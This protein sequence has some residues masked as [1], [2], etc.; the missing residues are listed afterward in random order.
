M[1][2]Q[3]GFPHHSPLPVGEGVK[4]ASPDYPPDGPAVRPG[5]VIR[6][7]S[8]N[9]Y[10]RS[11]GN[12]LPR[13]RLGPSLLPRPQIPYLDQPNVCPATLHAW[14]AYGGQRRGRPPIR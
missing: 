10:S 11:S 7:G 2:E 9:S 8:S 5:S 14:R 3:L 1:L 6:L 13:G 12:T 4:G